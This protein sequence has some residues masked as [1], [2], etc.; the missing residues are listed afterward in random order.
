ME[1]D[2]GERKKRMTDQNTIRVD[3][4]TS[5]SHKLWDF[6]YERKFV[7][8]KNWEEKNCIRISGTARFGGWKDQ[9]RFDIS[10]RL[11]VRGG[12]AVGIFL[13]NDPVHGNRICQSMELA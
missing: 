5:W 1:P 4:V 11:L 10:R 13:R 2:S 8:K 6:F 12:P 3:R 7:S 9:C